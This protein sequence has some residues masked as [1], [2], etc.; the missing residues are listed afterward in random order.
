MLTLRL[1]RWK[2]CEST[3]VETKRKP[4]ISELVPTHAIDRWLA[5]THVATP[6]ADILYAV[7]N[8]PGLRS[9][10][11]WTPTLLRQAERYALWRHHRNFAEYADVMRG[12]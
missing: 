4:R 9:D 2:R 3:S 11:R 6:D 1:K 5:R 7:R 10:A 8:A 12:H